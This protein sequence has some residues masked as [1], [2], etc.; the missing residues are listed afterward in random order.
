MALSTTA[1]P[2]ADGDTGVPPTLRDGYGLTQMGSTTGTATDFVITVT[3]PQV[4]GN[5]HIK[6]ILP[7]GY[8]DDP[9]RRYPVLY[10][11]HG[12]N[13]DPVDQNYSALSKS[14]SMITVIPDGGTRGWY[15]DWLDQ[16]T[17]LGAQNWETFHIRQVIPFIDAN[18]RTIAT[19]QAR[20]VAG[21]S[22][23]GFGAFHYAQN[24]PQLFG[25]TASLSGDVDLSTRFMVLRLAVV[26]SLV[27][28]K[29]AVDSDAAFGSPY[30]VLNA[31]RRWNEIDPS[32]HVDRFA[33]IGV[34]MYVGNG[35]GRPTEP[36]FWLE[37]AAENVAQNMKD[38]GLPYHFVD[39]GDGSNWGTGCDGSHNN[40]ACREAS[41]Q[42]LVHRLEKAFAT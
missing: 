13:A 31:D 41:L 33:G 39:Y 37:G 2:A 27:G 22:M 7:S 17:V 11:L 20:A 34:S 5:H 26:A 14:D 8:H 35:R 30:P 9:T 32:R 18:L 36:E 19:K 16:N 40:K 25:Q 29:P 12:A 21:L 1:T 4:T 24:H 6:I 23:G 38:L 10:W 42:D 3:T 28:Y 15:A